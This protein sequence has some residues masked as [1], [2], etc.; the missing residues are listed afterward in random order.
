MITPR[1]FSEFPPGILFRMLAEAYSGFPELVRAEGKSWK[2][3]DEF[4]YANPAIM[5]ACGFLSEENG[6]LIGFISWDPRELPESMEIGHNCVL[7]EYRERG[8]GKE[9]LALALARMSERKPRAVLV[10]TGT[11]PFFLPACRMYEAA[12]FKKIG[13]ERRDDPL[14][15]EI[16]AYRLD[17][18]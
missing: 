15:P 16:F 17:L 13:T 14:V 12:G 1:R 5:D 3:F 2:E 18:S 8:K 4:V 6:A 9:Q 10:R 7:P 11:I